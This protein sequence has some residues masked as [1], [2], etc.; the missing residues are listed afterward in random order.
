MGLRVGENV[1]LKV[2]TIKS[3]QKEPNSAKKECVV[4]THQ[5]CFGRFERH[6][7]HLAIPSRQHAALLD[8]DWPVDPAPVTP[9]VKPA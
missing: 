5:S 9:V 2:G 6:H 4:S 8:V 1:G 7:I 3:A